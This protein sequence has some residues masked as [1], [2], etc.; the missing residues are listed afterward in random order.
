V[1]S[2][3][4]TVEW[5]RREVVFRQVQ[6]PERKPVTEQCSEAAVRQRPATTCLW[7]LLTQLLR[8][9]CVQ[10]SSCR[11]V[12]LRQEE[13]AFVKAISNLQVSPALLKELRLALSRRKK[14]PAVPAGSRSSGSGAK[15]PQRASSQLVAV[16]RKANELASS[17]DSS[18]PANRR[19]ATVAVSAPLPALPSVTG[20][21]A[22]GSSR[23]LG[24][25]EGG[26][27]YAAILAGPV[28]PHQPSGSLKP[29]A[30]DSNPSES[31]ASSESAN[32]R[33]S[34]DMSG[35][36]SVKPDGTT[37]QHAQVNNT[38]LPSGQRPNKTPIFI[39]GATDTRTF[40]SWLRF[41]CPG[42]L[43]AQLKGENLMV[44]P[45]TADGFRD[46]VSALRSLDGGEGVSFHTFSSRRIA[47]CGFW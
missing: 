20:E 10:W 39:S 38:C 24:P 8:V 11:S 4:Y 35:P 23:Q 28:A 29:T 47:A 19:P 44:V 12:M 3:V 26:A 14:K 17:G 18:E 6:Q 45:S 41:S 16:K 31:A 33:M 37:P 46:V 27:T 5:L 30:M 21:Q 42:G 9:S 43:T 32:R 25:P 7:N 36:L 22:A 15:A 2:L 13:L 1:H 34:N 40:L